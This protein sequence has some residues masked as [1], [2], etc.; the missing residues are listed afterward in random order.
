MD[1]QHGTWGKRT[2]IFATE[3]CIVTSL[4][5]LP[6]KRCS[7]H[8]H[9]TAFNL[10]Y[11]EMGCLKIVTELGETIISEGQDF[12]VAPGIKHEFQTLDEPARVIE[13]AYVKYDIND[14]HRDKLGG[15]TKG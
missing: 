3:S 2:R 12:L 1:T 13:V 14:I 4:D 7:W 10:F 6:R 8:K 5:L 11:V 15:D 9:A